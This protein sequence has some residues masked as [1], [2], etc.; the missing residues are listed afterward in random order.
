M[1]EKSANFSKPMGFGAFLKI[2]GVLVHDF[3]KT[4]GFGAFYSFLSVV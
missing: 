1:E 2:E 3:D 4:R